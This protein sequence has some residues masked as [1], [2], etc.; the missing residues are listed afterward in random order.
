M[1]SSIT[2]NIG[3][4]LQ[5][6]CAKRERP[7]THRTQEGQATTVVLPV[8]LGLVLSGHVVR[9]LESPRRNFCDGFSE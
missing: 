2:R 3:F 8:L 7:C 9:L 4:P 5:S 1:P 6:S